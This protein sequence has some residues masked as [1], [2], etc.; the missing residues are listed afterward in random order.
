MA[1][2]N[3][4]LGPADWT[5]SIGAGDVAVVTGGVVVTLWSQ[6]SGGAQLTDLLDAADVPITE[7]TTGD[8]TILPKGAIPR[9]KGPEG[10]AVLW[11]DAG[12]GVRYLLVTTDLGDLI[13]T[14]TSIGASLTSHLSATNPHSSRLQDLTDVTAP[15]PS[16]GQVL[17]YSGT[18]NKWEPATTVGLPAVTLNT[19]QTIVA[20]KTLQIPEGDVTSTTLSIRIPTGDRSTAPDTFGAYL[21]VGTIGSPIWRRVTYLNEYGAL[22]VIA[23][24]ANQVPVRIKV[25][26]GSQSAHLTEWTDLSNNAMSWV[27]PDGRM[28]AP[29]LGHTFAVSV[30][31]TVAVSTGKHRVYNDTGVGL[32]I[33]SVRASAG[34]A[35][36]GAS[37]LV[38]VNKNGSTIFSTQANRPAIAAA[39]NTSGKV[40]NMNVTTLADGD[41]LTVDVDQIGSGTAGADLVVQILAY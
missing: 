22:R 5:F 8:G 3:F 1:R 17:I 12:A 30:S 15:T 14:V 2:Y 28:R 34:T 27:E 10:V 23:H 24:A 20:A 4:G 13:P 11:A 32:T 36:T 39:A 40:T 19:V 6:P 25:Y 16:D 35:P 33:R 41:F 26:D 37:I 38:D 7:V 29:N 21:N 9:F 18:T 31:G